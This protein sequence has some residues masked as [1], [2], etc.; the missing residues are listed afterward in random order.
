MPHLSKHDIPKQ[1]RK[2]IEGELL[3]LL[4]STDSHTAKSLFIEV[5]TE[6]EQLMLAKRVAT[7]L[8]LIDEQSYYRIQQLLGVSVSTSKRIHKLLVS[9]AF[10]AIEK[11][12]TKNMEREELS[13]KIGLFLRGG[14][15][16][17]AYVIK[18]RRK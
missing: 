12:V 13:R 5:I 17:R 6:T 14:L 10:P 4:F 8:M 7:I 16:P 1:T 11:K 2:K 3:S 9:G 15:P 18:K